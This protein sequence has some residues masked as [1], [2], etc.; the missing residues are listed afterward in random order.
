[1]RSERLLDPEFFGFMARAFAKDLLRAL[2][3]FFGC[4]RR[5]LQPFGLPGPRLK[6]TN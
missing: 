2:E 4:P 6:F 1:M 3:F 5:R